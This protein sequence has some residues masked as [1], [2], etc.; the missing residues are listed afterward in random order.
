MMAAGDPE[1]SKLC[2]KVSANFAIAA[3]T[4]A[5]ACMFLLSGVL[6]MEAFVNH[7]SS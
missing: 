4:V 1:G 7:R 6:R 3:R 2:P 5:G